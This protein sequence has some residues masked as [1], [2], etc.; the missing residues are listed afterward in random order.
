M[1]IALALMCGLFL[2]TSD[3]LCKKAL[4]S[5]D[6]L[7]VAWARLAFAGPF[8]IV[9]AF[10]GETPENPV[11]FAGW[12][13]GLVP[14]EILALFLYMGALKRSPMSLT[15]PFLAFT[16]AFLIITGQVLL[17]EHIRPEGMAGIG[18]V[19]VGAYVLAASGGGGGPFVP[20]RNFVREPG[21]VM[22]AGVAL[23]YSITA[24]GGKK[25]ILL[26]SPLFAGS[27][28]FF[29]VVV[30]LT[31]VVGLRP[32]GFQRMGSVLRQKIMWGIGLTQAGMIATHVVAISLAP[33]AHMVSVKRT[34]LFFGVLYGIVVFKEA[35]ALYRIPGSLLMLCGVV[36]LG[37]YGG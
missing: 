18:L 1:W 22:M 15:V 35:D 7:T 32:G 31:L 3:M 29:V 17:G 2:A 28:Y 24:S 11:L 36:V 37:L 19:V 21:C 5:T 10:T 16:P 13:A 20:F 34:S 23:I 33:A 25:L 6:T 30:V 4:A 8:L 14:L 27:V 9:L 12:L 26:S